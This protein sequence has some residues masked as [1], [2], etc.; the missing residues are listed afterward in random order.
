MIKLI[1]AIILVLMIYMVLG[2]EVRNR[3]FEV[4][5][6]SMYFLTFTL[7]TIF[8]VNTTGWIGLLEWGL[9]LYH[10]SLGMLVQMYYLLKDK[11]PD[12]YFK[13]A[14]IIAIGGSVCAIFFSGLLGDNPTVYSV[15]VSCHTIFLLI[16]VYSIK[17]R[18]IRMKKHEYKP[19][20]LSLIGWNIIIF[21]VNIIFGTNYSFV[22]LSPFGFYV[23][24]F[25]V[26]ILSTLVFILMY[27]LDYIFIC[28]K[29]YNN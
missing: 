3:K 21:T 2:M 13:H 20:I 11:E 5:M 10:C 24:P 16:S 15:S 18:N 19:C 25:I 4:I 9:P 26:L 28:E 14:N 8:T 6:S 29:E 22:T 17:I 27:T 12:I 7:N 23:N 1:I